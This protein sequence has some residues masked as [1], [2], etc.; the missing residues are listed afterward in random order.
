MKK[1]YYIML[2]MFVV[3]VQFSAQTKYSLSDCKRLAIENNKKIKNSQLEINISKEAKKDAFTNYFPSISASAFGYKAKN[4]LVE[5]NMGGNPLNFLG[6]GI[7]TAVTVFQ[8]IFVGGKILYGNKLAGLGVDVNQFQAKLSENDVL[9]NTESLYWQLV[10]L[11]EKE[12]TLN[13]IDTQ[14]DTLLKDVELSYKAGLITYNDVLKVK[15][16]KNEITSTRIN[17][18]NSI[19]L[20]KMSICQQIGI[21]LTMSDTFEIIVPDIEKVESPVAY[22]V[23]HKNALPNRMESKLLD[24][25]VEV[26][27]LQTKVKRADYLPTVAVCATYYRENLMDGWKG[28]GAVLASVSIPLSGWW[29]GSHAI[30]QQKIKEQIAYNDKVDM[31]EQL[32]LQM[33][34]V[35]NELNDAYKQILLAKEAIEQSFENLRLNNDYYRV[36]TVTLT[37]V[38]DAQ[39]LLQ[40]SRDKYVETYSTYEQ[41]KIKYLQVTGR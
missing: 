39:A 10:S 7:A 2:I 32:L 5:F 41:K 9:L 34:Q 23:D 21:E 1:K 22:Y 16:K 4:P 25:N 20:I 40:Q 6:D 24:K 18:D 30:K 12:R 29:G 36:G 28:N 27:R 38:L 13:I 17:L 19:K 3:T 33:Q 37:E 26:S 31:E 35:K 14:L 8:P 15:L 11:F